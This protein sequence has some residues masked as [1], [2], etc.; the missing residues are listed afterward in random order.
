[1]SEQRD[2]TSSHRFV[3]QPSF[4]SMSSFSECMR[5]KVDVAIITTTA[6]LC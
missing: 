6:S 1:M 3:R 4:Q 5:S 2:G